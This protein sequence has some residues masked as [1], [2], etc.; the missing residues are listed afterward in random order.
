MSVLFPVSR[1]DD[2]ER[3]FTVVLVLA[4]KTT[5]IEVRGTALEMKGKGMYVQCSAV[6]TGPIPLYGT[7][8]SANLL[9]A[10]L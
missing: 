1:N 8:Y 7:C 3:H 9:P 2:H 10:N 5:D 4:R 6:A